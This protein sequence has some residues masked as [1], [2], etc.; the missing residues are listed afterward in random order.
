[1]QRF[2]Q[3]IIHL[4]KIVDQTDVRRRDVPFTA[5][6]FDCPKDT[7]V[8]ILSAL[9]LVPERGEWTRCMPLVFCASSS[10]ESSHRRTSMYPV[11]SP[12]SYETLV[13]D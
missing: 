9:Q 8:F 4:V 12:I 6:D 10:A 7:D 13:A 5:K 1:M 3:M 2:E 11:P